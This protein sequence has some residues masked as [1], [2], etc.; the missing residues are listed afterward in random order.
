MGRPRKRRSPVIDAQML[1]HFARACDEVEKES[2]ARNVPPVMQLKVET[3]RALVQ[4]ARFGIGFATI[5]MQSPERR[6]ELGRKAALV[7]WER[8][9]LARTR[10]IDGLAQ[11]CESG[12][13]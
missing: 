7:R 8:A 2:W 5:Q 3:V 1:A 12:D 9:R 13:S 10:E 11:K 6:S 4:Q